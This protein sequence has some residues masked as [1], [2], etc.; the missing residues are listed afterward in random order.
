MGW[1]PA[2]SP[3]PAKV[4]RDGLR[5]RLT[6]EKSELWRENTWFGVPFWQHP[7]DGQSRE[8]TSA[9]A[10]PEPRKLFIDQ[11]ILGR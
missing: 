5:W 7:N 4:I 9:H 3:K 11:N 8:V 10:I 1:D 2:A 6:Y